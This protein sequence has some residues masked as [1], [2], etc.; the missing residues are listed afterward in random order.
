MTVTRPIDIDEA[1]L[2]P[3]QRRVFD[4]IQSGPRGIVEGPLRVWL[5]NPG[6]ADRA[7]ALG[8]YCRYGSALPPALSELAII[9]VGAHWRAGFEWAVHAPIA[10]RAGVAADVIEA[11]RTGVHP[12]GLSPQA[13]AVHDVT[14][15]L[16]ETKVISDATFARAGAALGQTA[17]IDLVGVLGYYT[18]ICMTINAFAVPLPAGAA[19]PFPSPKG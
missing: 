12:Q 8:A 16:L 17:M 14:A 19:D 15:E 2:T 9:M 1:T 3:D 4:A 11:I 6:L 5:M 7:Q 10:A 18:L 13:Q